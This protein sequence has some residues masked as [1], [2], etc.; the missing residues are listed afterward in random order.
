MPK[1]FSNQEKKAEATKKENHNKTWKS[2]VNQ[3]V[4]DVIPASSNTKLI[5]DP[6]ASSP[7]YDQYKRWAMLFAWQGHYA[8]ARPGA[9]IS[10]PDGTVI[11][12]GIAGDATATIKVPGYEA[13][14]VP[15]VATEFD[16]RVW[17]EGADPVVEQNRQEGLIAM[18]GILD[19]LGENPVKI[20]NKD[21]LAPREH[22][23]VGLTTEEWYAANFILGMI[24]VFGTPAGAILTTLDS[25]AK[26]A[27]G[28]MT[29]GDAVASGVGGFLGG[30]M[31]SAAGKTFGVWL[32]AKAGPYGAGVGGALGSGAGNSLGTQFGSEQGLR[33]KGWL[34]QMFTGETVPGNANPAYSHGGFVSGPGGSTE[35][36]I[37]AWLSNGEFVVNAAAAG[38]FL[39]FLELINSGWVPSADLLHDMVPGF[40][41]PAQD[42][43]GS[44][45]T[46]GFTW[47]SANLASNALSGAISGAKSGGLVKGITGGLSSL[48]SAAGGQIGSAI[49]TAIGTAVGGVGGPVGAAI[50]S[51]LGSLVASTGA[52]MVLKPIEEVA[53]WAGDTAKETIGSGFGLV[54]LAKSSGGHTARQD[55]Y[56]FNGMDPKSASMAIE[57]V[58]RRRTLAQQRGGGLGR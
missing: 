29:W 26:V 19:A 49:G 6:K 13:F 4:P 58:R 14:V 48:A 24:P 17:N 31:G 52:D 35:D 5:L 22:Q 46:G 18:R 36:L 30:M 15:R 34:Q 25:T 20:D 57:R 23:P 33:I 51:V 55:I 3:P 12:Y 8:N 28:D 27:N 2:T 42:G 11:S 56:N 47:D 37:P 21:V 44:T 41:T 43:D 10:M 16:M 1:N 53:G 40:A 38:N 45:S 39:P 7:A 9:Q 50:G 54:D 32:G